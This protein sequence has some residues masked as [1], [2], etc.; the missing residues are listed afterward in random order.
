MTCVTC[1]LFLYLQVSNTTTCFLWAYIIFIIIIKLSMCLSYLILFRCASFL[2]KYIKEVLQCCWNTYDINTT[3]FVYSV[4]V[5]AT[6]RHFNDSTTSLGR[7]KGHVNV[8]WVQWWRKGLCTS[9]CKPTWLP[10]GMGDGAIFGLLHV[11]PQNVQYNLFFFH[12]ASGTVT[13]SHH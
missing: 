6:F 10:K 1:K 3:H 11:G 9:T 4:N 2:C 12:H 5:F 8:L 7:S 13:F